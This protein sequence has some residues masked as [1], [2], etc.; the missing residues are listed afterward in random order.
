MKNDFTQNYNR[1]F[2]EQPPAT[3]FFQR[4]KLFISKS[5]VFDISIQRPTLLGSLGH[6]F[7]VASL[8]FTVFC[9]FFFN[10]LVWFYL[11]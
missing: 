4:P 10:L 6:L 8:V 2:N 7:A 1:T 11:C 5:A 9:F 3:L